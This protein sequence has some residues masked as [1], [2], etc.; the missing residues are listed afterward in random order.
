MLNSNL[1]NIEF[2]LNEYKRY[3]RQLLLNE[4]QIEGQKRLSSV[5][6]AC[7]GAGALGASAIT[8]LA[9]AG[10]INMTIL[11]D[12][13]VDISNLHRQ[14]VHNTLFL[15]FP[16]TQSVSTFIKKINPNCKIK[17]IQERLDQS[18]IFDIIN[19]NDLIIDGTDNIHSRYL[20]DNFCKLLGKPWVYGAVFQFEGQVSV[21]NYQGGPCYRDIYPE[22]PTSV[23][24]L[25]CTDGGVIGAIPGLIGTIQATEALK[26]ILGIG[27]ILS[28]H[29]F[30]INMLTLEFKKLKFR[31]SIINQTSNRI[32]EKAYVRKDSVTKSNFIDCHEV[33]KLYNNNSLQFIDVRSAVEFTIEHIPGALNHPLKDINHMIDAL[34]KSHLDK[35]LVI[36]CSFNSRARLAYDRLSISGIDCVILRNG[37]QGWKTHNL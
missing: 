11:D 14:P 35:K 3:S 24:R 9:A 6:V 26:T 28:G 31:Q 2:S 30:L 34:D 10:V 13:F 7:I 1:E 29:I 21:F 12:D 25:S 37:F 33:D 23:D 22:T 32:F 8:Y 17:T 16:K 18:N 27:N 15:N 20:I 19:S 5:R 36:Y 4:V